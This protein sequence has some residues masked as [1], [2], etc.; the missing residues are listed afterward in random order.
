MTESA[1]GRVK[2]LVADPEP[3]GG[4]AVDRVDPGAP[5]GD[6]LQAGRAGLQHM[7]GE[8]V[9]AADGTVELAGIFEQFSLLEPFVDLGRDQFQ[10]VFLENRPELVDE[11]E[12]VWSG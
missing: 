5:F 12:H 7:G 2:A 11:W 6:D 1:T 3:C 10:L 8:A 9:V 4:F